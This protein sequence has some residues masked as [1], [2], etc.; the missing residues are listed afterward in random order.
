MAKLKVFSVFDSAVGA[1]G[2]PFFVP[3]RGLA[4]RAFI[5]EA[6]RV[7]SN[8]AKHPL[9]FSL[10]ELGDYDESTGQFVNSIAPEC[11]GTAASFLAKASGGAEVSSGVSSGRRGPRPDLDASRLSVSSAKQS[12]DSKSAGGV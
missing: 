6:S 9:D 8:I 7:D 10:F 11:L 3:T 2:A 5:D 12:L 1:F 4:L